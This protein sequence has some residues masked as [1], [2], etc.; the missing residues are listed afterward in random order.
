MNAQVERLRNEAKRLRARA[1]EKIDRQEEAEYYEGVRDF[2]KR[3]SD[4]SPGSQSLLEEAQKYE[5]LA[6]RIERQVV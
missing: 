4:R 3:T 1:K 5:K 2:W 6:A